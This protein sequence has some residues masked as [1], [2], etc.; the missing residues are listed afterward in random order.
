MELRVAN[1]SFLVI[2]LVRESFSMSSMVG[3]APS[4]KVLVGGVDDHKRNF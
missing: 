2:G 1:T 3:G 4:W